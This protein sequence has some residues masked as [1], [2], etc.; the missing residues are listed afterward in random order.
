M[1]TG[2]DGLPRK[3]GLLDATS[4]VIGTMVGA[5]IFIVPGLI[6]REIPSS[7]AILA[8]WTACGIISFFGALAYAELGAMMPDSGGQYVYLREAYG[9][10]TAFLC[11]WSAFLIVQ[12]GSIAAVSVG[13]GIYA[14]YLLPR[15]P[16]YLWA[17]AAIAAF[18]F[19]NYR[20]VKAGA[21]TQNLFTFLKVA[22]LAVLI[23]S[24]FLH[25]PPALA[26]WS[27]AWGSLSLDGIVVAML[28]CF[29]AYDGWQY[30]SFVAGEVREP[31][32]NLPLSLALGTAAVTLLYLLANLA[33]MHVLPLGAIA[34][35]ERVAAAAA[36]ETMGSAGAT[37]IALTIMLSS[38]GAANGAI[39]TSPRLYFAQARDGLFFRRLGEVH[40]RFRTPSFSIAV[41]SVWAIVLALS[42]SYE[43]L[44]SYVLFAMWLFHA[45]TVF[46]VI[47]L[48]RRHPERPRPYRIFGYPFTPLLFTIFAFGFVVNTFATRPGSSL[49]GA[50]LIAA[51]VPMYWIWNRSRLR[52]AGRSR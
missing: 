44:L 7:A 37:V 17:P 29:I 32:R 16:G 19:I 39:L 25:R 49:V 20:G 28:G 47:V 50:V 33:Y 41:Q 21:R 15:A 4:I 9:E 5:G 52:V 42:G 26:G 24:A 38:A 1:S 35:T 40:P 14:S 10:L 46:A 43:T 30:V 34:A 51:G 22:G 27:F 3:L 18:S 45:L 36:V 48:R 12:S 31:Q 23:A 2:Q 11:G 13:F 8:I 6:A